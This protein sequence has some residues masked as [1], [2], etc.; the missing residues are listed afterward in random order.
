[1]GDVTAFNQTPTFFGPTGTMTSISQPRNE[2][3]MYTQLIVHT[4]TNQLYL[5]NKIT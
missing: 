3:C 1:M 4:P 5:H 2:K